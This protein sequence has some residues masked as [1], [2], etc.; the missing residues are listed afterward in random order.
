M[1]DSDVLHVAASA[2]VR[3]REGGSAPGRAEVGVL[4]ARL[5]DSEPDV[6]GSAAA[7][8]ESALLDPLGALLNSARAFLSRSPGVER[9][10]EGIL[11]GALLEWFS[12]C[13]GPARKA[14]DCLAACIIGE[15]IA[16]TRRKLA[17]SLDELDVCLRNSPLTRF[18]EFERNR[19]CLSVRLSQTETGTQGADDQCEPA[20]S[21]QV[22]C[23]S[24]IAAVK[25]DAMNPLAPISSDLWPI[26]ADHSCAGQA[27]P[28]PPQG[29]S[30]SH[31]WEEYDEPLYDPLR[32]ATSLLVRQY[33]EQ[34]DA[35][36]D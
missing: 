16:P 9:L 3:N 20:E 26:V 25:D 22:V 7:E 15:D 28:G 6:R 14:L 8:L 11:L 29:A 19:C 17:A 36:P 12:D 34:V 2:S 5:L 4:A 21:D 32:C 1:A 35:N 13:G 10:H 27:A 18:E 23:L 31:D 24:S 30:P 33:F